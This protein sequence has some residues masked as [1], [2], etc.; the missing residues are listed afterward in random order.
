MVNHFIAIFHRLNLL[1]FQSREWSLFF[2]F[3]FFILLN[4]PKGR[5]LNCLLRTLNLLS[6]IQ[7]FLE[8]FIKFSIIAFRLFQLLWLILFNFRHNNITFG[9]YVNFLCWRPNCKFHQRFMHFV[10]FAKTWRT[11]IIDRPC[12]VR[13]LII[14]PILRR[15]SNLIKPIRFIY[16]RSINVSLIL[17]LKIILEVLNQMSLEIS[18]SSASKVSNVLLLLCTCKTWSLGGFIMMVQGNRVINS[19]P[20]IHFQLLRQKLQ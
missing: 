9:T 6:F 4:C 11:I 10:R 7:K 19:V 18:S 12:F 16:F 17:P 14:E 2:F 3:Q 1:K 15:P 5:K 13:T 20:P 8:V